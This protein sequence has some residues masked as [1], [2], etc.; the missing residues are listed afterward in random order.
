MKRSDI[1]VKVLVMC[2]S[3]PDGDPRPRRAVELCTQLGFD[4]S[5]MGYPTG[6]T[7]ALH[8]YYPLLSP[9]SSVLHKILRRLWGI[10]GILMP[11]ERERV[12]CEK[13]RFGLTGAKT[14]LAGQ[15]FD[16]LIVEDLQLLPLAFEVRGDGKILFD[17]RE[18]YP[19]QNEGDL[20]FDLFEKPR[21]VQLCRDYLPQCDAVVTV[22]EGLRREFLKEFG[23]DAEVYRSTPLYVD[24][25]VHPTDPERIR[26]VYHGAANRNRRIE[27]LIE[28]VSLLDDRFSLDLI[29]TGNLR[30]Q[31]ELRRKA[32]S[33]KRVAFRDPVPIE[34]IIPTIGQYDVGFFY[35]EPTGF[36]IAHCL[37]NKLFEYIQARLMIAIGPSPD[38]AE[39]VKEYGCGVIAGEFSVHAMAKSLNSLSAADIDKYKNNSDR[40]AKELCFEKEK[41]KM[42]TILKRILL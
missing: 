7:F 38:M 41:N 10:V 1:P 17:A 2:L 37:P 18:Y 12:F 22:S 39:L 19:R 8:S 14:A 26:M 3:D 23:V 15:R 20:W 13:K 24:H 42:S 21:R 9:S 31:Q 5:V 30:Y 4:V 34:E 6:R 28:I 11:S 25:P 27:N 40:A 16:I 32:S 36:N 33:M 35:Y 29:L